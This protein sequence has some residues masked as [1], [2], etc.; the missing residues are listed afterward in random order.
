LNGFENR[1]NEDGERA[2]EHIL[3]ICIKNVVRKGP[4]I[5]EPYSLYVII[6]RLMITF[7]EDER[8]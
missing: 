6:Q 8:K 2:G 7:I 4:I 3:L 5:F 1:G